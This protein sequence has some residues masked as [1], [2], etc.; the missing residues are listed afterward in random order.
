MNWTWKKVVVVL[1]IIIAIGGLSYL[2]D[3][4]DPKIIIR[5]IAVV[6]VTVGIGKKVVPAV[7]K[8]VA[9]KWFL[10]LVF[11]AFLGGCVDEVRL[12][13]VQSSRTTRPVPGIEIAEAKNAVTAPTPAP[14]ISLPPE[15]YAAILEA[16]PGVLKGWNEPIIFA[17]Q[18]GREYEEVWNAS[19]LRIK[20]ARDE[21]SNE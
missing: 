20:C 4:R 1:G 9:S 17:I 2:C 10:A 11:P 12:L 6:L 3:V 16:L 8:K 13:G 18:H 19:L 21:N 7:L 5:N 14:L 15:V